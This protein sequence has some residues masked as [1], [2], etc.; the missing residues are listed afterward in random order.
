MNKKLGILLGIIV[1]LLCITSCK[2]GNVM[3]DYPNIEDKNHVFEELEI[4]DVLKKLENKKS[5]YLI[6]GFPEC[7]WCQAIMPVLNDVAKDNKVK[8]IYYI[9]IKQIR[10]NS[11]AVGHNEYK[12]LE[13]NYFKDALDVEKNRLNA[14][15]FVKVENGEMTMYHINTVDTHVL[16]ENMVLPPLTDTQLKELKGI[17]SKF[18][19]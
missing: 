11:E 16:N 5:F 4:N 19:N 1:L 12:Q 17:L 8:T 13:E 15:T 9:N 3:N 14:P 7:P 18:F 6:L 10:D 2:K